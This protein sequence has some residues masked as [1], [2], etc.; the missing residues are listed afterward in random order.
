MN[1]RDKSHTVR[2]YPH[3]SHFTDEDTK[4]PRGYQ[5]CSGCHSK[6]MA[7]LELEI[8]TLKCHK[9]GHFHHY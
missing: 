9:Y 6:E 8:Q 5:T 3:Y 7:K 4:V 2:Q 1:P